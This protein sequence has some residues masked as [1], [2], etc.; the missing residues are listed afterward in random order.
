MDRYHMLSGSRT[1]P[2][3]GAQSREQAMVYLLA[4]AREKPVFLNSMAALMKV[5]AA[6]V[7]ARGGGII[8]A[9]FRGPLA[10]CDVVWLQLGA[11]RTSDY[12]CGVWEM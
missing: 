6:D 5:T 11:L 3:L 7:Y 4:L 10:A 2:L 8:V 12:L 1:F 9:L